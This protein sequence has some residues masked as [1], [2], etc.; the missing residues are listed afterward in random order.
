MCLPRSSTRRIRRCACRSAATPWRRSRRSMRPTEPY[1]RNGA[2]CRC[3]PISSRSK[4]Q[5]ESFLRPATI[6]PDK[7]SCWVVSKDAPVVRPRDAKRKNRTETMRK[8]IAITQVTLDG[9]MQA[10]GGPEE[11]PSNGFTHGGWAMPF[12]D[13][14]GHQ[15]VGEIIA[16]EFD[17]L[18]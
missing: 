13:D 5:S 2:R 10:P 9:V 6:Q 12:F 15:A 1:W 4:R 17:L 11:D 18:L 7:N 8:I 3:R 14:A 16:G